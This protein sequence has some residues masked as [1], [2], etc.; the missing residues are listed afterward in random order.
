MKHIIFLMDGSAD[1][2]VKELGNKTPLQA[3]N[4]PNIDNLAKKGRNGKF[5]TIPEGMPAGSA[6]ANLSVLGYDP[7]ECFQGRG[8]L[9][10]ASMGIEVEEGDVALRCNIICVDDNKIKNHSA[11]HIS[12]EE[13]A[14]LIN[15]INEELGND[16]IKFY[17]GVSYRHLLLL[18]KGLFSAN[19]DCFAPHDYVGTDITKVLIKPED[20]DDEKAVK[21]AEILNNMILNSKIL[22]ERHPVNINRMKFAKDMGNMIWPWSPGNKPKMKT[23]QEVFGL[24]GA[25]ISAVD[26]VKGLGIYAGM[27]SIEVE[28]ATG[29]HDTNYEGKDAC[30]E[31]LEHYDFVYVHVEAPDEA[32]HEGDAKLK[33]KTIEDIDKRLIGRVLERIE[34]REDIA[35][36]VLPDHPTPIE[37]KTHTKDPVPFIIYHPDEESDSVEKFDEASAEKGSYGIIKEKEFIKK[38]LKKE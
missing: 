15:T 24:N 1:Y 38:L 35:I 8:V 18:K 22:L 12:N 32:G 23:Y 14:Q 21:T 16:M 28:G 19:I 4:K 6:V 7:R 17:P 33:V 27:R 25:V 13:G 2:P 37:L 3:A 36:A 30:L 9:E 26:L 5:I 34:G 20:K 11:G 31:A 29:L 10:A